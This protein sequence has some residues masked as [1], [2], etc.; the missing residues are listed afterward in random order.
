VYTQVYVRLILQVDFYNMHG[1]HNI[2]T[3]QWCF[4]TL[5]R[6]IFGPDKD[7]VTKRMEKSAQ[8]GAS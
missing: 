5:L 8:S 1:T 3:V 6:E 7:E 2:T 4:M